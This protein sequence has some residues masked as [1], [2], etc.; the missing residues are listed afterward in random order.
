M[1]FTLNRNKLVGGTS[2]H[3]VQFVKDKPVY[4]PPEMHEAVLAIGAMPSEE[5]VVPEPVGKV[6][7]TE[8]AERDAIINPILAQIMAKNDIDEFTASGTP[9]LDV[10]TNAAGFKVTKQEVATLWQALRVGDKDD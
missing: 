7:P 2:G 3:A 9:K 10:V 4:V 1:E 5:I 6:V 8:Q